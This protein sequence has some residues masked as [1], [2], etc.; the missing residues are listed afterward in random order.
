MADGARL[1]P[2]STASRAEAAPP[3]DWEGWR[4]DHPTAR[5]VRSG[6]WWVRTRA[7]WP[8]RQLAGRPPFAER[9]PRCT[10]AS[11]YA[12]V[13]G[14]TTDAQTTDPWL[15]RLNEVIAEGLATQLIWQTQ[16]LRQQ[17]E[18]LR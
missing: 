6:R 12:R 14:Q 10:S 17:V 18:R 1:E 2:H 7:R 8:G 3:E 9:R 15:F 13:K 5:E 4:N 16:Y 11:I